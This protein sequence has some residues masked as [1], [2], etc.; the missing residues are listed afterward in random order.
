MIEFMLMAKTKARDL[1][2]AEMIALQAVA[3]ITGDP[4][5]CARFLAVTGGHLADL[6]AKLGEAET[7]AA[8]LDYLLED[9]ALLLVFASHAALP[10]NDIAVASQA[11]RDAR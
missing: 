7:L 5:Q 4:T 1:E 9:E 10:P 2:T 8:V 6:K 11:L 3:F